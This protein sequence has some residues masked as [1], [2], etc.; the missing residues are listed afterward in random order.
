MKFVFSPNVI[1]RGK[2]KQTQAKQCKLIREAKRL[3]Q[4]AEINVMNEELMISFTALFPCCF[5]AF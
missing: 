2:Q 4:T 3:E 1:L 5:L